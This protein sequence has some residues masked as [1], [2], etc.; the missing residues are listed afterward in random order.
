MKHDLNA[1]R[2]EFVETLLEKGALRI[3]PS[4]NE[5]F[6]FKSGRKS[7][8]FINMGA[9][10]DGASLS[11]VKKAYAAMMVSAVE[12]KRMGDFDFVFGPAYKGIPLACL[13]C[14]GLHELYGIEK[15]YLY[16]R[17]EEKEYADKKMDQVLVGAGYFKQGNRIVLV[18]DVITTGGTKV[19]A[20]EKLKVLGQHE[21]VGM[22]LAVDR[23]EKMGDAER[24]EELSAVE[25]IEET[26]GVKTFS[27]LRMQ[28]IFSIVKDR[29]KPEIREAW[30]DYYEKYGA[31]RLG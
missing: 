1:V 28:D 5:L 3:A 17:K 26:F 22:V 29:I 16:D 7:P 30:V 24:V 10:T 23:Q 19:D 15:R 31:I 13:A 9:L 27:I 4:L 14:E 20:F 8:N 11:M 18:D 21:V 6:V 2:K 12:E 25:S